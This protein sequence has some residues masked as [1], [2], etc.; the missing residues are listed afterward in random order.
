M[1]KFIC[2]KLNDV[3]DLCN[4]SKTLDTSIFL[5]DLFVKE[6]L[7]EFE[8][9]NS[10]NSNCFNINHYKKYLLDASQVC[11]IM[12]IKLFES[13]PFDII[14]CHFNNCHGNNTFISLEYEILMKVG[15]KLCVMCIPTSFVDL[16][17]Q[18]I[19][20]DMIK[21]DSSLINTIRVQA[22]T[23]I[24]RFRGTINGLRYSA[25]TI[26][27]SALLLLFSKHNIDM[28]EWLHL[29]PDSCLLASTSPLSI[30]TREVLPPCSSSSS[31]S[32]SLSSYFD[33]DSCVLLMQEELESTITD[34]GN[35][36]NQLEEQ[37]QNE[38]EEEVEELGGKRKL[39]SDLDDESLKSA[40]LESPT[41]IANVD[42][43]CTS[44]VIS[45]ET[46]PNSFRPI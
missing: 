42:I 14:K 5:F 46:V 35:E 41:G 15:G 43:L 12:A 11:M 36:M 44:P 32:R 10:N 3:N 4:Y 18:L 38:K 34:G 23:L 26:A 16:L 40:R 20:K 33:A 27:I 19:P 25:V 31:S 30:H 2:I 21:D 6:I 29:I 8:L 1:Y 22:Y 13:H 17:I 45:A 24:R 7:E 39:L 28:A 9:K 37:I